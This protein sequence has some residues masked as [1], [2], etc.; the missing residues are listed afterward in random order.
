MNNYFCCYKCR[1]DLVFKDNSFDCIKCN[2]QYKSN[3]GI[4]DLRNIDSQDT[5]GFSIKKDFVISNIISKYFDNFKYFNGILKFYEK[6]SS[7]DD[8]DLSD[9]AKLNEITYELQKFDNPQTEDQIIHGHDIL[10]KVNL[11]REE[12]NFPD[13]KKN[14]CLENG[15]GHGLFIDGFSKNFE[16]VIV[17]DFS[18]SYLLICKKLCEERKI[19]NVILICASVE[20]L[21]IKSNLIDFIHSNNVIEHVTNQNFMIKE[22]SRVLSNKGLLFL[23]SPNKNSAYFEPHYGLPFYGF[24]PLKFRY[25]YIYKTRKIDCRDV[26][27]LNLKELK[28]IFY[29]NFDG[30][31]RLT[32]L[33]S[34]LKKTAQTSLIRKIIVFLISNRILGSIFSFL[35]NKL[36]IGI[37]PYHVIIAKKND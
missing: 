24:F 37:V 2:L 22:I 26:S 6:V 13:F 17:I 5:K 36:F 15:A 1:S 33:P 7:F 29:K 9:N 30:D 14:V 19:N 32:F 18:L 3:N 10:N 31:S 11:Y 25:W 20:D 12:F 35:I 16:K 34:K 28:N 8:N 21:P 27:L 4:F 23:L